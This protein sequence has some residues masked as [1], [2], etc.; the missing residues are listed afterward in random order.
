MAALVFKALPAG[1]ARGAGGAWSY[2]IR[3]NNTW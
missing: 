3:M 2:E 1:G